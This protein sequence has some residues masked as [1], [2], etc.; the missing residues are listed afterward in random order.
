M[1]KTKRQQQPKIFESTLLH[2]H[3]RRHVSRGE[4]LPDICS[5]TLQRYFLMPESV[6]TIM[7]RP[8]CFCA[9]KS[10][11]GYTPRWYSILRQLKGNSTV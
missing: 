2:W 8:Y 7:V 10:S 5:R 6:E 1:S 11:E 3:Y 9:A 4:D